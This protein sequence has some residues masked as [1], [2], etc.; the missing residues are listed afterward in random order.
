MILDA[1]TKVDKTYIPRAL[2][3]FEDPDIVVVFPSSKI[4]WKQHLIPS[5]KYYFIS[6][7]ERLNRIL[8]YFLIYGQTWKYTN[9]SFVVPGYCTI[10][11]SS[12]LK[13][14]RIDTPGLLIEDFN[15]A[16]QLHKRKL[17]KI[18]F[19]HSFI[20]WDQHPDN[21]RDYWKQVRRW[22]IGY[23]QTIVVN[24]FWPSFFWFTMAAFTIEVGLN[25]MFILVLPFILFLKALLYLPP[26][27]PFAAAYASFAA[28]YLPFLDFSFFELFLAFYWFDY[29]TTVIFG[30]L[31][32]KPQF[33]FYGLFFFIMHY[34][35]AVILLTSFIP[36]FFSKSDGKWSSPKRHNLTG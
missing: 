35:T 17:G 3:A 32:R 28:A 2:P 12:I 19:D 27:I 31:G 36:G 34:I 5:L 14:L 26:T 4:R 25:A 18:Y 20:A 10:Y 6:Y 21:L 7:R 1:D 11:R 16:F 15:L 29:M 23:F 30:I 13:Q 9:A 8:Q 22:N 24:G 33:L